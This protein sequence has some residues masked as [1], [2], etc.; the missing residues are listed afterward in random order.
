MFQQISNGIK[1]SVNTEYNGTRHRGHMIYYAFSYHILI[2]NY[3]SQT[4]QLLE[5]FWTI[6]DSLNTVESVRGIGVIGNTP[7]LKPSEIYNYK[8][9]CFLISSIG[10]MSGKYKM[11]NTAT[12]NEFYVKIPTFQLTTTPQLN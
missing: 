11:I 9:N 4:V 6:F 10:A 2:E 7:T 3:S 1:I 5:R 8:S 12:S